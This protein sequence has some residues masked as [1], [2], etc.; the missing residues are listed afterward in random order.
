MQ[1]HEQEE[2][3][4]LMMVCLRCRRE[5]ALGV[6]DGVAPGKR[7][8]S[9]VAFIRRLT[10]WT[11]A[12]PILTLDAHIE[13]LCPVIGRPSEGRASPPVTANEFPFSSIDPLDGS[14]G[15]NSRSDE[16]GFASSC[17]KRQF[18]EMFKN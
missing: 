6:N 7:I 9:D 11:T 17:V 13:M 16:A 12:V 2:Q 4:V 14:P 8:I 15:P 10:E 3:K 18:V 1:M 5:D